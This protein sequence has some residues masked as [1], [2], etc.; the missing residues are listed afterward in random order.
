[1]RRVL[2]AA[3][4]AT[5]ALVALVPA[6]AAPR[7]DYASFAR[8]VLPPGQSGS[9][10]FP[11]SATDQLA[12][13]DGLTPK[14]GD[15][16]AADLGRFF[17]SARFGPDGRV[18]RTVRP[19]AGVVIRRDRWDVPHVTGRTR[20]DVMFGA[21][22]VTAEDRGL[23]MNLLR[24]PGRVAALDVPGLAAFELASTATAFTPSPATEARLAAQVGLLAARGARGRRII[25][26]VDAYVAGINAFNDRQG[27]GI[28]PWTRND[29]VAVAALIGSVF[30]VGGGDETRSALLLDALSARLGAT[31]GYAVWNDLRNVQNDAAPVSVP[32]RVAYDDGTGARSGSSA[33]DDGSFVPLLPGAATPAA[34]RS[35]SNALL[36][37]RS[38]SATGRPLFVAGPQVGQSYPQLL[39]ELDLHGGGID[40]RGA[41]F[42]GISMYVL[43]GR[44]RDFAWSATSAGTD[45]VDTFAETLC[46]GDDLHYVFR[47]ECRAMTTLDAGTLQGRGGAPDR[48]IAL[49]ETVHGPVSGYATIGGRRVALT[50]LRSTRGRE[51]LSALLFADLNANVPTSARSFLR[52]ASQLEM[53]FN[54]FYADDR[55]IA[56]FSAGRLPLRAPGADGGLPTE[57]TGDHEW[58]GFLPASRHAQA[59]NPAGGTI[60]NWNN[61]PAHGFAAADDEFSW[62][63]IQRVQLLARGIE[64]RRRHTLADVVASMNAAATTDLRAAL[65]WPVV[66]QVLSG[67][68]A[69]S[70][71]AAR[72]AAAVTAWS[73]AGASRLDRDL[74]GRIDD[75]GAAVLDAAWPGLADAVLA[76]VL[77]PLT[78]RLAQVETR[79]DRPSPNGNAYGAGWYG[80]VDQDL[81]TLLGRQVPSPYSRRYCGG[82]DLAACRA[83]LW[84]AIE[85]A[86]AT[87]A[88]TQGPDVAAWRSD[89]TRERITFGF[90]PATARFTNRPTFQQVMSFGA[91]R[92]RR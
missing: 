87:L 91:H 21:G 53:T 18:V 25:A 6:D 45:I 13:Y 92:P 15:V 65:V 38:R 8:N 56:T 20:S 3:V 72:A 78:V 22:W 55:D 2:L 74:D 11:P 61:R 71:R 90:L 67:G 52:V 17:K 58:R 83:S 27:Y 9:L 82:G 79:D 34:H 62:G 86:A 66:A 80:Y 29:V 32:G 28:T 37:G 73:A 54:L 36:V 7:L 40:A 43:L 50:R 48:R 30:G 35:M 49:R 44:G 64:R 60:L 12:L 31:G 70:D 23:L 85:A 77:G 39:M 5:A 16:G 76:P 69:P 24:G 4:L 88:A 10:S 41:A 57:G 51:I 19:R 81:R 75:P 84:A 46:G 26:D 33:L 1:M 42:P 68:A 59:V 14:A 63:S 89:A 47:G